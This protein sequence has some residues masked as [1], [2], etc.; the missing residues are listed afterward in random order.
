MP[1]NAGRI[2][3]VGFSFRPSVPDTMHAQLIP[4]NGGEPITLEKDVTLVGRKTRAMRRHS[5]SRQ[6]LEAA[7]H[8]RQD[9]W[10]VVHP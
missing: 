8:D 1:E 6:R 9:R 10:A 4:L 5:R 7:V 2:E 3:E